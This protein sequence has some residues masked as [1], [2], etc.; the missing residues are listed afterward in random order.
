MLSRG[1]CIRLGS[2]D[3]QVLRQ[4]SAKRT[5]AHGVLLSDTMKKRYTFNTICYTD[6]LTSSKLRTI[7]VTKEAL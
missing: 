7:G 6:A 2:P 3:W 5:V 1:L 4:N